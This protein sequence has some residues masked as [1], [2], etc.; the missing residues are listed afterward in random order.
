LQSRGIVRVTRPFLDR[1]KAVERQRQGGFADRRP[2]LATSDDIRVR[3]REWGHAAAHLN[4]FTRRRWMRF[5]SPTRGESFGS[6]LEL[7]FYEE[8]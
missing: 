2:A 7:Q 5:P 1:R 4:E 8:L 6:I 3:P